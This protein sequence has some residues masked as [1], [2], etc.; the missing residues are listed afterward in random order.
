MKKF[1]LFVLPFI[2]AVMVVIGCGNMVS[3]QTADLVGWEPSRVWQVEWAGEASYVEILGK[4][5]HFDGATVE[6]AIYQIKSTI[7]SA[8]KGVKYALERS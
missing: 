1:L 7:Q 3:V 2:L 4:R 5:H 6:N 8:A